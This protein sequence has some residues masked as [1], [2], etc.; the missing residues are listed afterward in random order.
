MKNKIFSGAYI[1]KLFDNKKFAITFSIVLSIAIWF[2]AT[3]NR[4]PIRNQTFNNMKVGLSL[5]GTV[6]QEMG[7]G[8]VSDFSSQNFSVTV[9]GPNYIVSSLKPEDLV[10]TAAVTNVNAAG[11]YSLT[12]VGS[13]NSKK[14]GYNIVSIEPSTIDVT[15]DYIDTKEFNVVP[16][17]IGVSAKGGLIAESPVVSNIEESTIT[18]K[19]PRTVINSIDS[20]VASAKVDK[21][22]ASTQTYDTDITLYDKEDKVIYTYKTDGKVYNSAGVEVKNNYL[23][24]SKTSVKVTQPI[25]KKATLNVKVVF[26]NMPSGISMSDVAFT[27]DHASVDV[28][29]TPD[30]VEKMTEVTL[31]TID[32]RLVS[33]SSNSFE[34]SPVL[35]DGVKLMDNIDVFIV[36]IDTSEYV[37]RTFNVSDIRFTDVESGLTAKS[38]G[39]GIVRNVKIC[40]PKKIINSLNAKDLYAQASLEDK[41]AGEYTVD[42]TI[43]SGK[44]NNIWQVGE[45]TTTV[46]VK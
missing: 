17:L 43:K 2:V 37:V 16:Q 9:N 23:T 6:V 7:L 32:F 45:Y 24:L 21:T 39:A 25:S 33:N 38:S 46:T 19:G 42:L 31:S 22:L 28:I 36:K 20:V 12:V 15:F 30:V 26:S 29:G 40:G 11:K 34:L 44:H 1:R 41:S 5:E 13:S 14:T 18:I 8:I 4:N 3:A 35:P 10:L 27:V